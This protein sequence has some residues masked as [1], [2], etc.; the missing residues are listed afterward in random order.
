MDKGKLFFIVACQIMAEEMK[1][2]EKNYN[3][4]TEAADVIQTPKTSG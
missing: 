4:V 1:G 3:F 2:I